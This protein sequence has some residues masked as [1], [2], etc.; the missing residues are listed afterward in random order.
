[1]GR[2]AILLKGGGLC[3]G[4]WWWR[5]RRA[6]VLFVSATRLSMAT[7]RSAVRGSADY[8]AGPPGCSFPRAADP[9]SCQWGPCSAAPQTVH[10]LLKKEKQRAFWQC[11]APW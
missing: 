7:S 9:F 3:G 5:Q 10:K 8:G 11:P 1:M 4:G 6:A 2:A